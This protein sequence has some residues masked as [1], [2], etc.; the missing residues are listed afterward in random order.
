MGASS[1]GASTLDPS[2]LG[3]EWEESADLFLTG[4]GK[5]YL[6]LS[7]DKWLEDCEEA[8]ARKIFVGGLPDI[9]PLEFAKYFEHFGEVADAMIMYDRKRRRQRGFGFITFASD[10][11]VRN[12]LDIS[13]HPVKGKVVEVKKAHPLVLQSERVPAK[14]ERD[15]ELLRRETVSEHYTFTAMDETACA[16]FP[17]AG[18]GPGPGCNPAGPPQTYESRYPEA[19]WNT[20]WLSQR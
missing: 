9:T 4:G 8:D 17:S 2:A 7:G 5:S 3:H 14:K 20:S 11:G 13:R 19:P 18:P 10:E 15:A 16:S 12:A 1:M 6:A